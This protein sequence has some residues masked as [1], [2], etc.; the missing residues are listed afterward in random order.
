MTVWVCYRGSSAGWML[1]LE[2]S[3]NF[4]K[5][6]TA[7]V[8]LELMLRWLLLSRIISDAPAGQTDFFTE[9]FTFLSLPAGTEL[10]VFPF[11][12]KLWRIFTLLL[13]LHMKYS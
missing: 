4:D 11:T 7:S 2:F 10:L 9:Q 6:G 3:E 8:K 12:Q 1:Q 5:V 13:N